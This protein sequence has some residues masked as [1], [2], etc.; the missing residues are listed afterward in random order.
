MPNRQSTS[1][2]RQ[3]PVTQRNDP[4]RY[5]KGWNRAK[6][7]AL[8][9]HY[10]NQ[11]DDEAIA[12]IN[13]AFRRDAKPAQRRRRGTVGYRRDTADGQAALVPAADPPIG[14]LP[15]SSNQATPKK[16]K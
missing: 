3:E 14:R 4:N 13:A 1:T 12:E 5:P 16:R 6:V 8:I 9:E 10:E 11:T 7:Q 15:R 2:R